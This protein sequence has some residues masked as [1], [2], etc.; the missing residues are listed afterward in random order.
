MNEKEKFTNYFRGLHMKFSRLYAR[1]LTQKDLTLPQLALLNLLTTSGT[2]PMTEASEKL[3][4]SK[5]AVTYLVD[6]LEKHGYLK[7]VAHAKDRRSF[8]LEIQPKGER[9]AK[10]AQTLSLEFLF[11]T[12]DRFSAGERKVIGEFYHRLSNTMD[13]V[14]A[15]REGKR[16]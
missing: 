4:I 12:L 1:F 14:L 13:H 11:N 5:P 2:I 7:R 15:E 3:H 10:K 16:K 6:R 9:V 8:L